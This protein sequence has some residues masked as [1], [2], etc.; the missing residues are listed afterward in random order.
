MGN[1]YKALLLGLLASL[2]FAITFMVN[3]LM[4]LGGGSWVWSASLRFFWMLPFFFLIVLSRR[5]FR[6]LWR[7]M[8]KNTLQWIL[9]SSVGF[10]IFYAP[11]TFAA[12]Y[13]PSWLVASTW[14]FTIVAGILLAPL[15]NKQDKSKRSGLWPSLF[16]SGIILVGISVMQVSGGGGLTVRHF[17][18][19][20][21]P[22]LVAACAYPLG[23]RKM[24]QLTGGRLDVY[25]RI[26]GMLLGSLPFWLLLSGYDLFVEH[27]LPGSNQYAQTFIVAL[28]SGVVA[29]ALFFRATDK[30]CHDER[31]LAMVEATQSTEV[32]FA[33]LGEMLIL[34]APIPDGYA[35]V[36]MVLIILGMV[37]HSTKTKG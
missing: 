27:T 14:Q 28:S 21:L 32:L 6:V 24:M 22:V 15:I 11:L 37:L 20:I 8:K 34:N 31:S 3:R 26:L 5:N 36:G 2:F 17:V 7:E 4:S 19:G 25:Q 10:G 12:A 18:L 35:M 29:T 33:L 23:N 9:W 16:F 13:S 30:V 1:S